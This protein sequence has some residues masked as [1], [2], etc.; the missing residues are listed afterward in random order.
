VVG[1]REHCVIRRKNC[2]CTCKNIPWNL[3]WL[4]VIDSAG[5]S[6]SPMSELTCLAK[7]RYGHAIMQIASLSSIEMENAS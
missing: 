5:Q 4:R 6:G 1:A 3:I 7:R 2:P